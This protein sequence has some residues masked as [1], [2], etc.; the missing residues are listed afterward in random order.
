MVEVLVA[1]FVF[2]YLLTLTAEIKL[3]WGGRLSTATVLFFLNRYLNL[4]GL[5]VLVLPRIAV[6]ITSVQVCAQY[7]INDL[8]LI[9]MKS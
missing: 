9:N 8:T 1:L 3:F 5:W 2:E 4:A 6:Q 7:T